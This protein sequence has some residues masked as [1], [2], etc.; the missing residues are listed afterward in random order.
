[1][2]V[3]YSN[4]IGR[5]CIDAFKLEI[6]FRPAKLL[7]GLRFVVGSGRQWSSQLQLPLPV[8]RYTGW[9]PFHFDDRFPILGRC[10]TVYL[11]VSAF[12]KA[13]VSKLWSASH[14]AL[15]NHQQLRRSI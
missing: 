4:L 10:L 15:S 14:V 1:M 13:S 3:V 7:H 9:A 6:L 2:P 12:I 5:M 11:L 8:K